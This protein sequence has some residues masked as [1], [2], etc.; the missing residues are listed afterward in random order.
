MDLMRTRAIALLVEVHEEVL[1]ERVAAVGDP[2]A[3]IGIEL[4]PVPSYR[5]AA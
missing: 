1:V 2:P 4:M 3:Q 5:A